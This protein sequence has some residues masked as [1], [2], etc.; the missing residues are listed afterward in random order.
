MSYIIG[1]DI[2][3]SRTKIIGLKDGKVASAFDV[4]AGDALTSIYGAFGKYLSENHLKWSDISKV[5]CTGVGSG[6]L[7]E[8]VYD[9]PTE[10]ASEFI[11][12]GLGGKFISGCDNA[13]V[14][15][16]GTG[17]AFVS[18]QGDKIT[19][20]GGSG[21]G[22][23]TIMN[24]CKKLFGISKFSLIY[25]LAQKGDIHNI[26]LSIGDITEQKLSNME[27]DTTAA[28]FGK[29]SEV[30]TSEDLSLGL[31]NM[32]FESI[33][34]MAAFTAHKQNTKNIVM[35]GYMPSV[36]VAT[37]AYRTLEHL[38]DVKFI[39]PEYS[40][41]STAIGAAIYGQNGGVK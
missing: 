38:Y 3:G 8:P 5:V 22:G 18:V 40:A 1:I 35:T 15:S 21:L 2:G 27:A 30:A 6:V 31:F 36:S 4:K 12:I 39:I 37:P 23:G 20:A 26:D 32:V 41:Y 10:K 11:C 17:T 14:V 29:L 19:H 24:L 33:G 28:N 34:T 9:I 13:V 16:M 7:N 25:D